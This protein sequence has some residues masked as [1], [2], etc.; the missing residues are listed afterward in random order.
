MS[1]MKNEH[2]NAMLQLKDEQQNAMLQLGSEHMKVMS[3]LKDEHMN[4][5]SQLES[6]HKNAMLQLGHEHIKDMSQLKDKVA[7]KDCELA[8]KNQELQSKDQELSKIIQAN[9]NLQSALE[10]AKF[11]LQAAQAGRLNVQGTNIRDEGYVSHTESWKKRI[12]Q[13]CKADSLPVQVPHELSS[14][15]VRIAR[16]LPMI[17]GMETER[18]MYRPTLEALTK[19]CVG[20][21]VIQTTNTRFLEGTA[22]DFVF[23][24]AEAI[25]AQDWAVY[26]ILE[27]KHKDEILNSNANLGQLANYLV[28]LAPLQPERTEFWGILSNLVTSTVLIMRKPTIP[29]LPYLFQRFDN[30]RFGQAIH[31]IRSSTA[32]DVDSYKVPHL[33]PFHACLGQYYQRWASSSK[34]MIAEFPLLCHD[35][36][37]ATNAAKGVARM[38]VKVSIPNSNGERAKI[39]HLNELQNLRLITSA[40][41]TAP[42][43][44]PKLVWDPMGDTMHCTPE[45]IQFG[46]TPV[47]R[48]ISVGVFTNTA[49]F[50]SGM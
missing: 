4:P 10:E 30:I 5:M 40:E 22:P 33:L 45:L 11:H 41:P 35:D 34:W 47:G 48:P 6:E 7:T 31:F 46:I 37:N 50:T 39:H 36:N 25:E 24:L 2:M 43:S 32:N 38:V 42:D 16:A 12:V 19:L 26:G 21:N 28:K 20:V 8:L 23:C 17:R 27:L 9:T 29:E 15:E 49:Q 18:Q 14:I 1:R 13:Q 44:I 3:Q